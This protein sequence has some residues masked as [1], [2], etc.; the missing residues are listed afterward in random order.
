[1]HTEIERTESVGGA[2]VGRV[3]RSA[4]GHGGRHAGDT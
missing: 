1:M 4:D 2:P 3:R